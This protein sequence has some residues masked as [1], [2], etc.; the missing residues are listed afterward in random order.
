MQLVQLVKK[1][2]INDGRDFYYKDGLGLGSSRKKLRSLEPEF[3]TLHLFLVLLF[4][5]TTSFINNGSE[6]LSAY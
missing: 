5:V 3:N 1:L 6:I 2:W 4:L